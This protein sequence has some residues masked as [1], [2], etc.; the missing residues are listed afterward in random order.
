MLGIPSNYGKLHIGGIADPF[1]CWVVE[2][3]LWCFSCTYLA[4]ASGTSQMAVMPPESQ[5]QDIQIEC[6]GPSGR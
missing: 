1:V 2:L 3:G 5:P 6:P 4:A